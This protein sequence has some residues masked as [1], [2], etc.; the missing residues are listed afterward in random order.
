[1]TFYQRFGLAVG[2]AGIG[3]VAGGEPSP[4]YLLL[5]FA[6]FF[7]ILGGDTPWAMKAKWYGI[8]EGR[9]TGPFATIGQAEDAGYETVLQLFGAGGAIDKVGAVLHPARHPELEPN[10]GATTNS[11]YYAREGGNA[12]MFFGPYHTALD[13]V[14][15]LPPDEIDFAEIVEV[16][17]RGDA[18]LIVNYWTETPAVD[19][20]GLAYWP[21]YKFEP[22]S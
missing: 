13:A 5:A 8:H 14:W 15:S 21:G 16:S 11:Y 2:L 3:L 22:E 19:D 6:F 20:D 4:G 9:L 18:V 7:I 10:P 17:R 12:S 1:M